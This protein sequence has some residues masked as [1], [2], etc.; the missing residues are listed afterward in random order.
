MWTDLFVPDVPLIEKAI[1][2]AAVYAFLL[3][4]LAGASAFGL[5]AFVA[6]YRTRSDR[7]STQA[8][9]WIAAFFIAMCPVALAYAQPHQLARPGDLNINTT[10]TMRQRQQSFDR[11][12]VPPETIE[13]HLLVL[14]AVASFA[15]LGGAFSTFIAGVGGARR[16][17]LDALLVGMAAVAGVILGA[18][19]A[20]MAAATYFLLPVAGLAGGGIAGGIIECARSSLQQTRPGA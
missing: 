5:P 3:I 8:V 2:T 19:V 10:E 14:K 7:P 1:R 6:A 11:W 18:Y 13:R 20:L 9:I 17:W 4:G 16:R 15:F 12:G